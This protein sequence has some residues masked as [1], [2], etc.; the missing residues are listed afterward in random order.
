MEA[1]LNWQEYATVN[2]SVWS[3]P[4]SFEGWYG[5]TGSFVHRRQLQTAWSYPV[6]K[7]DDILNKA[8][9]TKPKTYQAA[10]TGSGKGKTA[11]RGSKGMYSRSAQTPN[12]YEGR[13]TRLSTVS[14]NVPPTP[15][16]KRRTRLSTFGLKSS[17]ADSKVD[18]ANL[19]QAGLISDEKGLVKT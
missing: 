14:P 11:G 9:S 1:L 2:E 7:L 3:T 17:R 12:R 13:Q 16:S 10:G 8:V 15:T 4:E 19:L 18:I 5:R 6:M